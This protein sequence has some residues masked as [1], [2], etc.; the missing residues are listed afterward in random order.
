MKKRQGSPNANAFYDT[1]TFLFWANLFQLILT[2][3]LFWLDLIPWIGFSS[4][5]KQQFSNNWFTL[6]CFFTS[7]KC[8]P[9]W[10][11]GALFIIVGWCGGS[12]LGGL[13]NQ[14]SANFCIIAA[15]LAS[16]IAALYW[17]AFPDK[18]NKKAPLWSVLPSLALLLGGTILW[19]LWEISEI[20]R[21]KLQPK[22]K[23]LENSE[24]SIQ[25][26]ET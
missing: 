16:P 6:V 22:Y 9:L 2:F 7:G 1:I 3:V 11:S 5:P 20:K 26:S 14:G 4:S 21:L 18:S 8:A 23:V 24:W 17:I 12:I 19:K 10:K 13:V 15:T 25:R